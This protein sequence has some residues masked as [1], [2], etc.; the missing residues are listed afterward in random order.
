MDFHVIAIFFVAFFLSNHLLAESA[1]ILGIF[2][3]RSKSHHSIHQP[4]LNGL[5]NSGHQVTIIGHFKSNQNVSNYKEILI[6]EFEKVSNWVDCITVEDR[7]NYVGVQKWLMVSYT[8]ELPKCEKIFR[9]DYIKQLIKSS[10]DHSIDLIITEVY[11]IRCFHLLAHK[12]N[13]PLILI[14]PPS[15]EIGNDYFVGNPFIPSITPLRNTIFTT[16]MNFWQ[17]FENFFQYGLTYWY[18]NIIQNKD[19]ERHAREIFNMTLPSDEELNRKPALAFYNNHPSFISRPKSPNVIDIAGI[20][21]KEAKKLPRDIEEFIEGAPNGVILFSFGT[22][23]KASSMGSEKLKAITDALSVIPQRVLWRVNDLNITDVS[24]NVKLGTWFPQRD[25]LEHKK[26]IAFISHCGLL[27]T[28][29][30]IYTTTPVIGVPFML[31]QFQ[32]AN[33]LVERGVGIYVD[34]FSMNKESLIDAI[35]EITK[36]NKYRENIIKWSKIIQD[37]PMSPLDEALYWTEYVLKHQG[38]PHLRIAAADMPL[39]QYLLLDVLA[40]ILAIVIGFM[41]FLKLIIKCILSLM[42]Q[43]K[44]KKNKIQ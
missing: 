36:N 40:S 33:I 12:L 13:V 34:Y 6:S 14:L 9:F 15:S 31:D 18:H 41:Y 11:H 5:A 29:E 7:T 26:V 44:P 39:Y 42:W 10:T 27:G 17:R 38:A 22:T 28:L 24:P 35:E 19:M 23:I 30:A 3:V 2:S 4:I 8:V 32:N 25:I 21:I 43:Q 16:K 37:R 20:H 1:K